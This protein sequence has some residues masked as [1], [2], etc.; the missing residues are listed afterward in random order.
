MTFLSP[1]Y[2]NEHS[3]YTGENNVALYKW[4]VDVNHSKL[5][6]SMYGRLQINRKKRK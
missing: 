1:V 3:S 4:C 2:Q 6:R 5:R